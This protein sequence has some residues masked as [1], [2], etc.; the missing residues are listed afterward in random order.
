MWES[1]EFRNPKLAQALKNES[2]SVGKNI[3]FTAHEVVGQF[4]DFGT[5]FKMGKI[6][7]PYQFKTSIEDFMHD[8]KLDDEKEVL[9]IL[10]S[11]QSYELMD[12]ELDDMGILLLITPK[13]MDMLDRNQKESNTYK[14]M[15]S[16]KDKQFLSSDNYWKVKKGIDPELTEEEQLE[17]DRQYQENQSVDSTE[18]VQQ[19]IED[20]INL[21]DTNI[22]NNILTNNKQKKIIDDNQ[23]THHT[24]DE[25]QNVS[26][27]LKNFLNKKN[28]K[29]DVP[30]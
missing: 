7:L 9:R 8:C 29:D 15:M 23:I 1:A 30:F 18:F 25:L 26:K 27:V 21:D 12:F 2:Y 28:S 14:K 6:G 13:L 20:D 22:D 17:I 4:F 3:Y 19:S 10:R 11:F 5:W 24:K 16:D